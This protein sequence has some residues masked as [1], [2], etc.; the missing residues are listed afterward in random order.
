[1]VAGDHAKLS[2]PPAF[3][4]VHS[5]LKNMLSMIVAMSNNHCIGKG[6]D[7]PWHLSDELK[8]F[9]QITTGH[10]I[11][12]GRKNHE[13]IGRALPGRRNIVVTRDRDYH[14]ADGCEVFHDLHTALADLPT[15]DES[16]IIGGAE[17]YRQTLGR[18]DRLYLTRVQAHIDGDVFFAEFSLNGWTLLGRGHHPIDDRHEYAYDTEVWER[19]RPACK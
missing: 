1:M 6:N 8:R 11:V 10:A 16:F 14:A 13:S 12:M 18:V 7:L 5:R 4:C 3:I 19:A 17:I 2:I 15:D 9:R